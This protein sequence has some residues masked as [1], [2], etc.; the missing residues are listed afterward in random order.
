MGGFG[1]LKAHPFFEGIDWESLDKQ[2]PPELLP[3]L[4]AKDEKS[5]NLWGEHSVRF[6]Y[7]FPFVT[8]VKLS[9]Q[10]YT[11]F[12]PFFTFIIST[13]ARVNAERTEKS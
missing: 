11:C 3:Y 2:T 4:P 8:G 1:P 7:W 13:E 6:C 12:L 5:E 9:Q 10:Q